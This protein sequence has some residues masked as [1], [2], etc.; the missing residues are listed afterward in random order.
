[1]ANKKF[2]WIIVG[3]GIAGLAVAEMLC[4]EG[5][6]VLLLEKNK[7]IA[8]ETSK[9]FH[10]WLHSGTLYTLVPDDMKTLRYLLG[11]TDDLFEY[12]STFDNMNLLPSEEGVVVGRKGWFN[13]E[14]IEYR[15]K[16]RKLNPFWMSL[17]SRSS[18]IIDLVSKHDWLRRRAGSEYGR[19]RIRLKYS[20]DK[21]YEQLNAKEEF[22]KKTSPDLTMNSRLLIN[23]LL[24]SALQNG[25][26]IVTDSAVLDIKEFDKS[27]YAVTEKRQYA[28]KNIAI[29]SPDLL[30][31]LMNV[32]IKIGYAPIAVADNVPEN[33][34][35]FVE[36]DYYPKSCINL[37]RKNNGVGQI[38]GISLN[39]KKD[40]DSYLEYL[41]NQHKI[42]NPGISILGSYVGIKKELLMSGENRNYLYHVNQHSDKVWSTVLGK[43]S[44][45]FS[46]AP[47]FFRRVFKKNPPKTTNLKDTGM[48]KIVSV[49]SWQE[50]V[51]KKRYQNGNN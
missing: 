46:M 31:K 22:L 11:A 29:C 20:L 32:K 3:G 39:K 17:V 16:V 25:L 7:K 4:R 13:N 35:S 12:Y 10:E 40:V 33:E 49:T 26:E 19:S 51:D 8:S 14:R 47:E 21:I 48:K 34:K 24:S 9:E 45:A 41:I 42:R 30:A 5:I 38:G 15:Y 18:N 23:D 50:L 1:M 2:D 27:V 28:T 44:L 43:F 6:K 36:L 37:L